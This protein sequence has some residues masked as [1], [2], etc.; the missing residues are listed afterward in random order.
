LNRKR[1]GPPFLLAWLTAFVL[2]FGGTY[3]INVMLIDYSGMEGSFRPWDEELRL[4]PVLIVADLIFTGAMVYFYTRW[5]RPGPWLTQG[6]IFGGQAALFAVFP[7]VIRNFVALPEG[8]KMLIQQIVYL[9]ILLMIIGAV[10][11]FVYRA[12]NTPQSTA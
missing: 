9:G 2:W 6:L 12:D 10:L 4:Y 1:L 7:M 11:A 5:A 3:L 8:Q